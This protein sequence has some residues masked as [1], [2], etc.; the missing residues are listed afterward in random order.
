MTGLPLLMLVF[1]MA[2]CLLFLGRL[3]RSR[4][5]CCWALAWPLG[6]LSNLLVLTGFGGSGWPMAIGHVSGSLSRGLMLQ[7][8]Y[9]LTDRAFPRWLIPAIGAIAFGR[10]LG[11]LWESDVVVG[12]IGVLGEGGLLLGAAVVVW[13]GRQLRLLESAMALSLAAL[14]GITVW[15]ELNRVLGVVDPLPYSAYM[16]TASLT[17]LL[18]LGTLFERTRRHQHQLETSRAARE[19]TLQALVESVPAGILLVDRDGIIRLVN[20]LMADYMAVPNLEAW[21]GRPAGELLQQLVPRIDQTGQSAITSRID[22]VIRRRD[23]HVGQ[24]EIRFVQPR[25][26]IFLSLGHPVLDEEEHLGRVWVMW[27]VTEERRLQGRLERVQRLET[28]GTL[29]GGIAHDYNNQMAVVSANAR[30]LLKESE[31]SETSEAL[32]DIEISADYCAKL[33]QRLLEFSRQVRGEPVPVDLAVQL[34]EL[35]S[36]WQGQLP[37]EIDFVADVPDGL[38][39]VTADLHQLKRVL[40]SVMQNAI[41]ATADGGR[42]ELRARPEQRGDVAG[43]EVAIVD[44]GIGID[45]VDLPHIFDPFFT[46]KE[47]GQGPGLGLASAHGIVEG[48]GGSIEAQSEPGQGTTVRIFWPVRQR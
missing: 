9:R 31:S 38:P 41:E 34:A 40:D 22:R 13:R 12:V 47:V 5:G 11:R 37:R 14:G 33:T 23:K 30:A 15:Y 48:H 4:A 39:T 36:V 10:L 8:S 3:E 42:I 29:A 21:V 24:T 43:V 20:P 18:Q 7:G 2:S 6:Y 25:E 1:V 44:D 27:E 32:R 16:A 46:T 35:Q 26:R 28:L 17:G 19:R 45:P